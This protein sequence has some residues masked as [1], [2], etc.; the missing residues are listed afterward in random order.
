[1]SS[2][3]TRSMVLAVGHA[4]AVFFGQGVDVEALRDFGVHPGGE[5]GCDLDVFGDD[6]FEAGLGAGQ[7]GAGEDGAD[8]RSDVSAHLQ[9][10]DISLGVLLE[11]E[12]VA[13]PRQGGAEGV[14]GEVSAAGEFSDSGAPDLL[15]SHA[16]FERSGCHCVQVGF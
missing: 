11:V 7:I 6:L 9:A 12:L 2:W 3:L 1:M 8:I 16:F 4:S 10:G 5:F 15:L 14:A 13:L